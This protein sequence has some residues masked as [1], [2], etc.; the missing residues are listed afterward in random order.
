MSNA[1]ERPKQILVIDDEPEML[2]ILRAV[3]TPEG[4]GVHTF[5]DPEAALV[6]YEEHAA[7]ID[8]VLLDYFM[9]ALSGELVFECLQATNANVYVVLLTGCDDRVAQKMIAHGLRGVIPKPFFIEYL[10][11]EVERHLH[12]AAG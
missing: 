1:A 10:K 6:Y 5:S 2:D 3:L 8:L 11:T 4:Y 7:A 9:P 12:A